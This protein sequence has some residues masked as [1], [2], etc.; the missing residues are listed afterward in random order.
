M[1]TRYIWY[2]DLKN[3]KMVAAQGGRLGWW[4][5]NAQGTGEA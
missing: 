1:H 5:L 3:T 2:V 4:N